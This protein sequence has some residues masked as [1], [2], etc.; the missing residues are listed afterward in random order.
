ML[1]H[2]SACNMQTIISRT[3]GSAENAISVGIMTESACSSLCLADEHCTASEWRLDSEICYTY[4]ISVTSTSN[5]CCTFFEKNC[6]GE[7][8]SK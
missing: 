8:F 7:P 1:V 4:L 6:P 2:V 5:N 3:G